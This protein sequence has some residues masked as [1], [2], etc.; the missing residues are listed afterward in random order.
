MSKLR[1][2]NPGSD[3]ERMT[4]VFDLVTLAAEGS[5]PFDLDFMTAVT[6]S[7]GQASSQGAQ[8][9][10]AVERSRRDDRSRD[11]L[12]NQLKM[13]S[14][15]YRMLGWLRPLP[16]S[17]LTFR[18][19]IL[20]LTISDA[21]GD[22]HHRSGLVRE[23]LLAITFP[24][25]T[26]QN[27]GVRSQRPFKWLLQLAA[28]LD[29]VITRHEI[30]LG[31]LAYVDDQAPGALAH[32]IERIRALRKG[33]FR[34][35]IDAAAAFAAAEGVQLTTL[36]NYTRFPVGVL[37]SPM[38]RWGTPDSIR[39]LYSDRRGVRAIRLS[40]LG[41]AT[42]HH[43]ARMIDVRESHLRSFTRNDRAAFAS[44]T[45]YVM[46]QRAGYEYP[47]LSTELSQYQDLSAKILDA[48]GTPDPLDILFSPFVQE[49]DAV[50]ALAEGADSP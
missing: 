6:T 50:L 39:G 10:M 37:T 42:A 13:Y 8:G 49:T 18:T 24:N 40:Q 2:P 17:R 9:Q 29:G 33:P 19:S 15:I 38:L 27:H 23:S 48:M 12:Y 4:H 47:N 34:S 14:E 35:L 11:P 41:L 43:A 25:K 45:Y 1:F 28:E 5:D 26:T 7:E 20:G 16:D 36:E 46:L 32:A 22:A 30:I 21:S 3:I 31:L 44:L